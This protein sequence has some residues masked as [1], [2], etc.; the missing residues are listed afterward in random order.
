MCVRTERELFR[1]DNK[2]C[3]FVLGF[4]FNKPD[5]APFDFSLSG[6][7]AGGAFAGALALPRPNTMNTK[8]TRERIEMSFFCRCFEIKKKIYL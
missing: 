5:F 4:F 8:K 1:L 2:F 3:N 6:D 7:R